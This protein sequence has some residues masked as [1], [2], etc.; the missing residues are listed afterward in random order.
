MVMFDA[1][2][3]R[4]M[5]HDNSLEQ[6]GWVFI[7]IEL[8]FFTISFYIHHRASTLFSIVFG[9]IQGAGLILLCVYINWTIVWPLT[10]G[11]QGH[12]S[13]VLAVRAQF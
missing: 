3:L 5:Y 1:Q 12:S 2:I 6:D 10:N 13:M 11:T 7:L 4:F 8:A 9:L